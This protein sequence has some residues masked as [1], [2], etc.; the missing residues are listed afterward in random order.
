MPKQIGS[1]FAH[2]ADLYLSTVK[3]THKSD[4]NAV[5]TGAAS[6]KKVSRRPIEAAVERRM[7]VLLAVGI[8]RTLR[9]VVVHS[10]DGCQ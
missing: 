2:S 6:I 4:Q 1:I 7:T 5:K 10:G 8:E 9:F 3:Y